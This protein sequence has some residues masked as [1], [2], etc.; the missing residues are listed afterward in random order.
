MAVR[1]TTSAWLIWC[2]VA[3]WAS[4]AIAG[5]AAPVMVTGTD[6]TRIPMGAILAPIGGAL[7]TGLVALHHATRSAGDPTG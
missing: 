4:V 6:P 2:V 3:I 1:H 5:V 7:A